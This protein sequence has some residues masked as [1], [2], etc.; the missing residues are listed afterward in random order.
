[1]KTEAE[2]PCDGDVIAL[3]AG[4][5]TS[6]A[7]QQGGLTQVGPIYDNELARQLVGPL[8]EGARLHCLVDACKGVFALGLPSRTYTRADG[9]TAWEAGP[10]LL[11]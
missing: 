2:T 6:G 4:S 5:D 7:A 10:F 11:A 1:M 3:V 9:W 8:P